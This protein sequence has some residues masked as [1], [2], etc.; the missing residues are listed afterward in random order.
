MFN[1]SN[2]ELEDRAMMANFLTNQIQMRSANF[3]FINAE[4][5]NAI[6]MFPL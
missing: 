6:L 2:W 4:E 5:G 1:I 3:T